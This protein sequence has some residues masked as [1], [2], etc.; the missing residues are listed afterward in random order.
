MSVAQVIDAVKLHHQRLSDIIGE[1]DIDNHRIS[2]VWLG[3]NHRWNSGPPLLFETMVFKNGD[4]AEEYCD[5][6]STWKEAE[7]GHEKAI[8]WVKDGC[9]IRDDDKDTL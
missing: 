6:Y 5:R 3:L 1:D 7:E 9:K 4:M 2:T 8:Q